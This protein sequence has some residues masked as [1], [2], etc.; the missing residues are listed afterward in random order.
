MTAPGVIMIALFDVEASPDIVSIPDFK[1]VS[2]IAPEVGLLITYK[3]C[4]FDSFIIGN[5][6]KTVEKRHQN[7]GIYIGSVVTSIFTY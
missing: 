3:N 7:R 2:I 1:P 5:G 6:F 4:I